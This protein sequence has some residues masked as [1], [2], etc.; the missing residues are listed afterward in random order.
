MMAQ[1]I[2]T[3]MSCNPHRF[4]PDSKEVCEVE[5]Y[6]KGNQ[7]GLELCQAAVEKVIRELREENEDDVQS[8]QLQASPEG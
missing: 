2:V 1:P 4:D 5:F 7:E 3:E 8:V 6:V